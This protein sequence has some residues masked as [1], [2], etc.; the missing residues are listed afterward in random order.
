MSESLAQIL[1]ANAIKL[2]DSERR[3]ARRIDQAYRILARR[4]VNAGLEDWLYNP[5]VKTALTILQKFSSNYKIREALKLL[6]AAGEEAEKAK[7][8]GRDWTR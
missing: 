4:N 2:L 3:S 6:Q 7:K 8:P 1:Y 5:F